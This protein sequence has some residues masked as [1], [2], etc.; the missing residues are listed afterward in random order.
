MEALVV[1]L[2]VWVVLIPAG[3]TAFLL[4]YPAVARRRATQLPAGAPVVSLAQ[5]R[6]AGR[7]VA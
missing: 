4:A 3:V 7:R 2:L 1:L 5:A 6:A